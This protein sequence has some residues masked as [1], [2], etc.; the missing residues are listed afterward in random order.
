M[1]LFKNKILIYL[2]KIYLIFY[3]KKKL[4]AIFLQ[5]L[6]HLLKEECELTKNQFSTFY[7]C[8]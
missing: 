6:L 1:H 2:C 7:C 8:F 5:K 4:V 3:K